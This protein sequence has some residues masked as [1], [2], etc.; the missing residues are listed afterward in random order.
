MKFALQKAAGGWGGGGGG[1]EGGGGGGGGGGG[2]RVTMVGKGF[3]GINCV[4][5]KLL[6]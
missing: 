5:L 4:A 2:V 6:L 1:G 3:V